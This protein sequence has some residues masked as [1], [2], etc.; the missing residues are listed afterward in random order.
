MSKYYKVKNTTSICLNPNF[1]CIKSNSLT[2]TRTSGGSG[3]TGAPNFV[4]VPAA[5]DNGYGAVI[6]GTFSSGSISAI[7]TVSAGRNYNKLPTVIATGIWGANGIVAGS[8]YRLP[9]I[10]TANGISGYG[11]QGIGT[12]TATTVNGYIIDNGGSGYTN[13]SAIT[14]N[15]TGTGGSGV[16]AT[17]TTTAGVITAITITAAGTGYTTGAP[18]ITSIAGGGSGAVIRFLL[19]PVGITGVTVINPGYYYPASGSSFTFTNQPNGAGSGAS[20]NPMITPTTAPVITVAFNK[21]FSAT[22][23]LPTITINDLGRLKVKNLIASGMTANTPYTF[24]LKDVQYT[25]RDMYNSDSGDPTISQIISGATSYNSLTEAPFSLILPP[26]N[27]SQITLI[28]DDS[29]VA[30]DTGVASTLSYAMILEI[31]EFDPETTEIND[32]YRESASRLL[33]NY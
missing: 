6:T 14:F 30:K 18:T 33:K 31:E 19:A 29:L 22:W 21:T 26:Q 23:T 16:A 24:R 13:G 4:V 11:F 17:I 12:L 28:T 9:P 8:G 32:V 27:I 15:N 20:A 25:S 10:V 1:N 7:T 5:G 3:Y 2:F